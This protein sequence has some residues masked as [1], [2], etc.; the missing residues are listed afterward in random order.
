MKAKVYSANVSD[1]DGIKPLLER[2]KE[3]FP[4][5]KHLWLGAE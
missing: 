1:R 2:A 3:R 5:M 4:L